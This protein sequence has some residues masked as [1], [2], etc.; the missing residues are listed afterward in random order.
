MLPDLR[1]TFVLYRLGFVRTDDLPDLAARWLAADVEDGDSVRLLAGN[2]PHDPAMLDT[3]IGDSVSE[4][5]VIIP[6]DSTNL[7]DIAVDWVT[8]TWRHTDDTRW[9]VSTLARLGETYPGF[10]LGLWIGL[11]DEWN[12]EWGRLDP[13]L[14]AA[15]KNE[16]NYFTH[17]G[18]TALDS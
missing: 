11:D 5:G 1:E 2:D 13:D 3:L 6:S 9:A 8:S 16:L 14:K 12:G 15:A 18:A 4:A 17:G 10:D 7:R